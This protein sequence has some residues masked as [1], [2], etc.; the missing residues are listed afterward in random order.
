MKFF[1][2]VAALLS[3]V[4]MDAATEYFIDQQLQAMEAQAYKVVFADLKARDFLP[5]KTDVNPGAESFAY[6]IL[7]SFGRADFIA[8][9]AD[10]LL[11]TGLRGE[12]RVGTVEG[13]ANSYGYSAQDLRAAA[14][15]Q[16]PLDSEL[17]EAAMRAHEER[18]NTTALLGHAKLGFVGLF[19]HPDI[20]VISSTGVASGLTGKQ[21]LADLHKI[22]NKVVEQSKGK[23]KANKLL[24]P[25]TYYNVIS[26]TPVDTTGSVQDTVLQVFQRNRTDIKVVDWANELETAGVAGVKRALAY[27]MDPKVVQLCIPMEPVQHEPQKVGLIWT[28]PIESR[29]GGTILRQP[30]ACAYMDGL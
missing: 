26:T 25:L 14:M 23:F 4:R 2:L 20:A 12:K 11:S 9:Y 10:T 1:P 17:M 16:T 15:N 5:L 27:A 7:S 24:L 8:D 19:N 29:F 3:G 21:L 28:R 6:R 18:V 30:L 22:A 13:I